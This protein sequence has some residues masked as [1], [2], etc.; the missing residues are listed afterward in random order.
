M[1]ASACRTRFLSA[2]GGGHDVGNR[3]AVP[4]DD[5]GLSPLDG[6]Q[7]FRQP[8]FNFRGLNFTQRHDFDRSF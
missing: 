6:I 4:G 1:P 2:A 3:L 8:G 5:N 7:K